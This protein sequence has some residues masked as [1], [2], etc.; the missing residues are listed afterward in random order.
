MHLFAFTARYDPIC[1]QTPFPFSAENKWSEAAAENK[2]QAVN[3][4][5]TK[6]MS[7]IDVVQKILPSLNFNM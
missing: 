6:D 4:L 7:K 5:I 2:E 1:I 3:V